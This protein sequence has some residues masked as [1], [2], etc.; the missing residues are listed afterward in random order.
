[1]NAI[2]VELDALVG[3]PNVKKSMHAIYDTMLA[4][5]DL[6]SSAKPAGDLFLN[7]VFVGNAG[8]GKTTLARLYARL[9]CATGMLSKDE[10]VFKS[11]SDFISAAVGESSQK[12][13]DILKLAEGKALFIDEAY[14][15]FDKSSSS[16]GN[17]SHGE[18]VRVLHEQLWSA[19]HTC[20]LATSLLHA[21]I[22]HHCGEGATA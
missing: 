6:E 15:L 4:N 14:V 20:A 22:E 16:T 2:L 11:A 17:K 19:C 21:G 18:E 1:V 3:I 10:T 9:L 5:W 8:T 12:T 7:R 13:K